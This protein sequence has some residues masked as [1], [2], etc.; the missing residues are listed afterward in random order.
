MP[1]MPKHEKE[2]MAFFLSEHGRIKHHEIC[3]QCS[4]SCKQSFHVNWI[5]C[6]KYLRQKAE[7]KEERKALARGRKEE[8]WQTKECS[9]KRSPTRTAS[10]R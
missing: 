7:L 9:V 1:R 8:K 3:R 4:C 2:E 6:P 10:N 5:Y